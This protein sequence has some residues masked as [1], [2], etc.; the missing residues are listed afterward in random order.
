M[1]FKQFYQYQQEN[2]FSEYSA[3]PKNQLDFFNTQSGRQGDEF[4]GVKVSEVN[5]EKV[6][7][8]LFV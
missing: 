3:G 6:I 5:L 8:R 4:D 1:S 2:S 7:D